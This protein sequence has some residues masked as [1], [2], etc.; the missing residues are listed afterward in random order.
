VTARGVLTREFPPVVARMIPRLG[1][2]FDH[3]VVT[4]ARAIERALK[5]LGFDW[6][7]VA[8]AVTAQASPT[9][10]EQHRAESGEARQMRAWLTAI[11]REPWP[12][13]WTRGFVADLLRHRS[14][15]K[16]SE[17]QLTC[18]DRIIREAFDRGVRPGRE[19]A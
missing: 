13:A 5:P 15:D 1:S 17:R 19:A 8:A 4:S 7:D 11:L 16:L 12:N 18:I 2:P 6:H 9:Q 3:E 10:Y 14:L